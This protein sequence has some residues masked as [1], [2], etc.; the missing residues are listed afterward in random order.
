[1]TTIA[2]A[3]EGGQTLRNMSAP[4]RST[5]TLHPFQVPAAKDPT[6]TQ[7]APTNWGL[8]WYARVNFDSVLAAQ[9]P[10][11]SGKLRNQSVSPGQRSHLRLCGA[12]ALAR[13]QDGI[14]AHPQKLE[15]ELG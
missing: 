11:W 7:G 1:M 8:A 14:A 6:V 12:L 4:P 2:L 15:D 10:R 5:L 3:G 9:W 13:I